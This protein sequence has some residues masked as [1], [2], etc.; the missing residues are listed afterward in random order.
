MM[1]GSLGLFVIFTSTV[2]LQASYKKPGETGSTLVEILTN[3][4]SFLWKKYVYFSENSFD[5]TAPLTPPSLCRTII[6]TERIFILYVKVNAKSNKCCFKGLLITSA[7][8]EVVKHFSNQKF[9]CLARRPHFLFLEIKFNFSFHLAHFS[10]VHAEGALPLIGHSLYKMSYPGC[11]LIGPN[12]SI[13]VSYWF[14]FAQHTTRLR[15]AGVSGI[16]SGLMTL[17]TFTQFDI[18]FITA[19]NKCYIRSVTHTRDVNSAVQCV[20][21]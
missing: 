15:G 14:I 3:K 2:S 1:I 11:L 21:Q 13:I 16:V 8:H 17:E 7:D 9:I 10:L 6:F 4:K 20:F 19:Q 18:K 5:I 12:S